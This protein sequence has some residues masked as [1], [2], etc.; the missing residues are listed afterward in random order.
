[1]TSGPAPKGLWTTAQVAAYLGVSARLIQRYRA[2]GT[3]TPTWQ[4]PKGHARWDIKD[5]EEQLRKM[6]EGRS[7]ST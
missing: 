7:D 5:V 6:R 2:E 3:L 4:T 1:M